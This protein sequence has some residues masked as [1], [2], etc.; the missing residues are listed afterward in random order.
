[1]IHEKAWFLYHMHNVRFRAKCPLGVFW[2]V[3]LKLIQKDSM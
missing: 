2:D 3:F 1:M